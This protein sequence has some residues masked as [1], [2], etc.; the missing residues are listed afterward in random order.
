MN[1]VTNGYLDN[2]ET[3]TVSNENFRKVLFTGKMQLVLMSLKPGEDIGEEVHKGHDQFFRI[4]AG[5]GEV[6]MG[7][8]KFEVSDGDAIVIP[9]GM[10][11]NLTNTSETEDLK[12]YTIYAPAE[13]ADGTVH[14]TKAESL[15]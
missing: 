7:E 15:A 6:L 1:K 8:E 9:D 14:K 3:E 2:I 11:H 5:K 4:D 10:N 12:I 13:H